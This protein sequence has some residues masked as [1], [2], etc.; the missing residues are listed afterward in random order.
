MNI[1]FYPSSKEVE[2]AVP[3]PKPASRYTPKWYKDIPKIT[4]STFYKVFNHNSENVSSSAIKACVPFLDALHSGYI[5]ETWQDIVFEFNRE[6]GEVNFQYPMGEIPIMGIRE[7]PHMKIDES[8]FYPLEFV[9]RV[10]WIPKVPKGWSVFIT[11]PINNYELPFTNV[12]GII[13]SDTFYHVPMGNFPFYLKHGFSGIIP[14]GTPMFQI[15]PIKRENWNSNAKKW[16][17]D[18]QFKRL[19]WHK[20]KA[21]E[22]YKKFFHKKK[23]YK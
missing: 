6:T 21:H 18:E 1:E 5:Q 19:V 12:S 7:E 9:W 17:A 3:M 11:S 8:V 14:A 22:S 13:D 23:I 15:I 4:D 2:L 10:P 16:D 20:R